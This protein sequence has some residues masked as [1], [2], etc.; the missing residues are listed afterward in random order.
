MAFYPF[1]M[2]DFRVAKELAELEAKGEVGLDQFL[3]FSRTHHSLLWPAFQMQL[4]LK[5]KM[6]GVGFWQ[7]HAERRVKLSKNKYMKIKDLL[8]LVRGYQRFLLIAYNALNQSCLH[9]C[10][11]PKVK[12]T[13]LLMHPWRHKRRFFWKALAPRRIVVPDNK[14]HKS[15]FCSKARA[16]KNRNF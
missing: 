2:F 6:M 12:S 4:A 3:E 13:L 16:R 11:M 15:R 10:S 14:R 5:K 8:Q 7:T 1:F 9:P